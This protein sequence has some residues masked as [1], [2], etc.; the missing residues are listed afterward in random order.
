MT[1]S[2]TRTEIR[3]LPESNLLT[4]PRAPSIAARLT[5]PVAI[6]QCFVSD[7]VDGNVLEL[8]DGRFI[9]H[10]LESD[11]VVVADLC[12]ALAIFD[13]T[14]MNVDGVLYARE[15]FIATWRESRSLDTHYP[16]T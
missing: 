15:E 8:A 6:V 13:P 3:A 4:L 9:V 7:A 2:T 10:R 1:T 14:P 5:N 11:D 12:T 16:T